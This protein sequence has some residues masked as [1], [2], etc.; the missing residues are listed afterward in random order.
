R[1]SVLP[2]G[3][4]NGCDRVQGTRQSSSRHK[5]RDRRPCR[6]AMDRFHLSFI[7]NSVDIRSL[8]ILTRYESPVRV[9]RCLCH[10]GLSSELRLPDNRRR[11]ASVPKS[12]RRSNSTRFVSASIYLFRNP[13]LRKHKYKRIY[14]MENET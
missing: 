9:C 6:S 10:H 7:A 13:V 8:N 2:R 12:R 14:T 4:G 3:W 1:T 11:D 5:G